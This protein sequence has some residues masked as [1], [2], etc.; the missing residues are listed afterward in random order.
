MNRSNEKE[1]PQSTSLTIRYEVS[2]LISP[3][4]F[5]SPNAASRGAGT[6]DD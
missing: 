6:S 1:A 5:D 3:A 4:H 2:S